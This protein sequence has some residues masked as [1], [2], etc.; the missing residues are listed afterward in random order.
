M[1]IPVI[2]RGALFVALIPTTLGGRFPATGIAGMD[3][4]VKAKVIAKSRPAVEGA[5]E[6]GKLL[7]DKTGTITSGNRMADAPIPATGADTRRLAEAAA[8]AFCADGRRF[9]KGAIDVVIRLIG[10]VPLG[11]RGNRRAS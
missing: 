9:R 7:S 4:L 2:V 1:T 6:L 5:G 8:L 3:R 11:A 10:Q